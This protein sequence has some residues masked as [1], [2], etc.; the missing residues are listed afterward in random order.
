MAHNANAIIYASRSL[1]CAF[2]ANFPPPLA[3]TRAR[4]GEELV[5][6][7][8]IVHE[9]E[10][11]PSVRVRI[12]GRIRCKFSIIRE[13]TA[14]RYI[15]VTVLFSAC[16]RLRAPRYAIFSNIVKTEWRQYAQIL[17][18]Y[19]VREYNLPLYDKL[20]LNAVHLRGDHFFTGGM[21]IDGSITRIEFHSII[22]TIRQRNKE[23]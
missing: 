4:V 14:R 8:G 12:S 3:H 5:I 11:I 16:S 6:Q 17:T 19:C 10:C 18:T 2:I 22:V 23:L 20:F 9:Y 13:Y 1:V 15:F 7:R 21:A